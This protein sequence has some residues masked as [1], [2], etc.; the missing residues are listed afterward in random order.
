MCKTPIGRI[1]Y[2]NVSPVYHGIDHG[3]CPDW[4]TM[5]TLPPATLN[6]MLKAGD[7]VMSP[8]SS[9]AYARN[10]SDWLLLPDL[11]I[12]CNGKVLSVL[13]VSDVP[14]E[15]LDGERVMVTEES[16]T[17]VDLLRILF[18]EKGVSPVME[19]GRV[20]SPTDLP[21]G[22]R[23]AL[24]IGDAALLHD[25]HGQFPHVCDLGEA[26]KNLT[27][28]PFVFAVW[29]IRR[30]FCAM[31]PAM[32]ERLIE[33]LHGSR[34]K[35]VA[36]RA[37]VVADARLKTGLSGS[38]LNDYF[39]HLVVSLGSQEIKGLTTFFDAL[40]SGGLLPGPVTPSFVSRVDLASS[41]DTSQAMC[42]PSA[43]AI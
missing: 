41:E 9:A 33:L 24:V 6:A 5:K 10:A 13:F 30:D 32:V 36:D 27:G 12:S 31:A 35:G 15:D 38:I 22:V 14:M 43:L 1:S 29:A 40:A 20:H 18:Q 25:W 37:G 34:A 39:N 11:S 23:G 3:G 28:L 21:P 16:A 19:P 2:I 7:V 26:W 4:L 17:S 8:V 42:H